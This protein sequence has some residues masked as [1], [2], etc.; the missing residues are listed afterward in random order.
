MLEELQ[1]I[2]ESLAAR[3][4][5]SVAIDDPQLRLLVHTPHHSETVDRHRVESIMQKE[6]GKEATTW[7]L[8]HEVST[9]NEPV[10]IPANPELGFVARVCV[11]VRCR[12]ILLAYLWLLDAEGSVTPADLDLAAESAV[13]A[14]EV[15][16]RER[17]LGDLRRGHE[18]ELLR[19]LLASD[20]AVRA[21][22]AQQLVASDRLPERAR[23]AVLAV[24]VG[25]AD[26]RDTNVAIDLAL[27]R[28]ERRLLPLRTIWA[29]RGGVT[30]LMLVAGR[31]P[32]ATSVT[33]R[34]SRGRGRRPTPERAGR[35][36][37][38]PRARRS[39]GSGNAGRSGL[40][41]ARPP[42]RTPPNK[43]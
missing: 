6:V 2:A 14:G 29:T 31:R 20:E 40:P 8:S 15:L 1:A 27:Q 24:R 17:L 36:G 33:R 16:Y 43:R 18:R 38:H 4:R 37:P 35:P 26:D 28:A 10:R 22:A 41:K 23:V 11:P 25:T 42:S 39:A 5:R 7:T 32:P 13:A 3:L 30:G 19:D 21:H 34:T 12:G 9:A